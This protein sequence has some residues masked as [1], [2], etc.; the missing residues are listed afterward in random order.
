MNL[1]WLSRTLACILT[2]GCSLLGMAPTQAGQGSAGEL[3]EACKAAID[4]PNVNLAIEHCQKAIETD[5]TL[6]EAYLVLGRIWVNNANYERGV[7]LLQRAKQ[8]APGDLHVRLW[9][10]TGLFYW[11]RCQDTVTEGQ[12][13]LLRVTFPAEERASV[14]YFVGKCLHDLAQFQAATRTLEEAARIELTTRPIL[15]EREDLSRYID[16]ALVLA[17]W[18]HLEMAPS[19]HGARLQLAKVLLRR[20]DILET[21]RALRTIVAARP[22]WGEP[23]Y[24]LGQVF[25]RQAKDTRNADL[26]RRY[27][28]DARQSFETY[29]RLEPQGEHVEEVRLLLLQIPRF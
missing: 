7:E 22:T 23:Y 6:I 20:G 3:L 14:L 12:E 21:E 19:D 13:A 29:I 25:M 17:Y 5:P 15:F 11:D 1:V 28:A 10:V 8:R 16:Q 2:V 24:W 27:F 26:A 18:R 4:V 9:L